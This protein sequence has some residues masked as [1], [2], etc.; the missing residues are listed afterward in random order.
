MTQERRTV[1]NIDLSILDNISIGIFRSVPS[2]E[3]KFV[4]MNH[5]LIKMFG[6]TAQ[7]DFVQNVRPAEIYA[8]SV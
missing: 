1:K 2:V 5:A 4:E 3:G 7:K 8:T 6:Y